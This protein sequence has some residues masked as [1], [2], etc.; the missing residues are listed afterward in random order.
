M[1]VAETYRM[2]GHAQHDPQPYVPR[3]ELER[4]RERDPLDRFGSYLVEHGFASEEGLEELREEVRREVDRAA[5]HAVEAPMPAAEEARSGVYGGPGEGRAAV[6]W[7]RR[8]VV[9]YEDLPAGIAGGGG[10]SASADPAEG[11]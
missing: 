10:A 3:E 2:L 5:E 7:T 1:V 9:G 4:W 11:G 6:P 8:E